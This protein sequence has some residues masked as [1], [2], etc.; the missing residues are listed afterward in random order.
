MSIL[1]TGRAVVVVEPDGQF[2]AM[3]YRREAGGREFYVDAIH[4]QVTLL[5]AFNAARDALAAMASG[6]DKFDSIGINT[7]ITDGVNP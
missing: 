3:W 1:R 6:T 7:T 5:A 2:T 4:N